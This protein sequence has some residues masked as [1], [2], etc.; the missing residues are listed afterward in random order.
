MN[1]HFLKNTTAAII[2]PAVYVLCSG[3][4][5]LIKIFC[6]SFVNFDDVCI[7]SEG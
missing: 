1:S 2:A 6:Q 3:V 4:F 5:L 7:L